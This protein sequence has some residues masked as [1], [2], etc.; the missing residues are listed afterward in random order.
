MKKKILL[1]AL[2]LIL[3]CAISVLGTVAYLQ[4]VTTPVKNTFI[5]AGG[6]SLA[7]DMTLLESEVEADENGVYS[8]T[9]NTTTANAYSV[10]PG[11]VLPKDPTI[12]IEGKTSAPAYL[13]VEAVSS[14]TD[15][16]SWSMDANWTKLA[17]KGVNG[18]DLYVYNAPITGNGED[19]TY[20]VIADK[21][22]QVAD[23]D[24]SAQGELALDFYAY[25]AQTNIG[26]ET[27]PMAVYNAC[28]KN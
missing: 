25:L 14:L 4:K 24:L 18:G 28:F 11:A 20:N 17:D 19:Q 6:G 5:A 9:G 8:F 16:Y 3:V 1:T 12:T 2:A 10:M 7:A 27:D 26:A 22:I 21:K 15:A 13:Y 23:T